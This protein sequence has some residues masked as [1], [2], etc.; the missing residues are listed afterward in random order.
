MQALRKLR[1]KTDALEEMSKWK[2]DLTSRIWR[3]EVTMRV[4]GLP[5]YDAKALDAEVD[6]FVA[7][8][9]AW[10]DLEK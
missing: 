8:V 9:K 7:I 6:M 2:E 4:T 1:V 3:A 10:E 5:L